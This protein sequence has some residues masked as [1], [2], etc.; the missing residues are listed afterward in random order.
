MSAK[1][2]STTPAAWG[3]AERL[4]TGERLYYSSDID[5]SPYINHAIAFS[6]QR[7]QNQRPHS[8]KQTGRRWNTSWSRFRGTDELLVGLTLEGSAMKQKK[9][10]KQSLADWV[11][12]AIVRL[13]EE[14]DALAVSVHIDEI[15]ESGYSVDAAE[16]SAHAMYRE[17]LE[18]TT[19]VSDE[20]SAEL[21]FSLRDSETLQVNAPDVLRLAPSLRSVEP[22]SL[23]LRR[24]EGFALWS[25]FEQYRLPLAQNFHTPPAGVVRAEYS[26]FRVPNSEWTDGEF[27]RVVRFAQFPD[28]PAC[29]VY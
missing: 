28:E 1:R 24:R 26:C 12:G 29:H 17:L 6:T 3:I 13:E 10:A 4:D 23:Y 5:F 7:K 27:S 21:L 20:I 2:F 9:P 8:W 14:S 22:P 19:H 11:S 16:A 25:E 15:L 18:L